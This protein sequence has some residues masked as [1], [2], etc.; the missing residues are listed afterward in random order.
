MDLDKARGYLARH[1][2]AVLLTRH[3]DGRPQ[4]SPVLVGVD[5]DGHAVISTREGAAKTKNVRRDPQVA[6]CVFTDGFF[7]E[8]IQVEGTAEV[9]S[10]PE[11]MD[12]LI[13][14]YRG[15]SGEH[16]DW[17]EYREAMERERRVVLRITLHRA[18]PDRHA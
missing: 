5:D 13:A 18:G 7:G 12:H 15:I 3:A 14:Y 17:A 8:W 9:I 2:H 10:L 4:M 1:H 11:A 6:V 16:P